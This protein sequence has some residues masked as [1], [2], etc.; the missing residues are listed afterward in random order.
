VQKCGVR[1]NRLIRKACLY[2][3]VR[4]WV[5]AAKLLRKTLPMAIPALATAAPR[6]AD[7][8]D[9]FQG[10]VWRLQM[11]DAAGKSLVVSGSGG[12]PARQR[13]GTLL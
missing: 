11:V 2:V 7:R 4:P 13:R 10:V 5:R 3:L 6:R 9:C 8:D 12:R 1:R